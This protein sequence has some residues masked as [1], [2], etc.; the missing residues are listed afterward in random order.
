MVPVVRSNDDNENG[1]DGGE[2]DFD[3][4]VSFY[5]HGIHHYIHRGDVV[6]DHHS[7]SID[8]DSD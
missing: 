5:V 4:S 7:A 1:G 3:H 8:V 6:G 2:I